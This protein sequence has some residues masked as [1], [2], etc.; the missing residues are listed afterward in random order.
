MISSPLLY[1]FILASISTS[2]SILKT[3]GYLNFLKTIPAIGIVFIIVSLLSI[4][5]FFEFNKEVFAIYTVTKTNLLPAI[6]FLSLLDFNIVSFVKGKYFNEIGCACKMGA[7]RYWFLIVLSLFISLFSQILAPFIVF[8]NP[9]IAT[10]II[11]IFLSLLSSFTQ[12]KNINGSTEVA[13]TMLY[14]LVAIFASNI[15]SYF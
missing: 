15:D 2:I 14:L 9:T 12:L 10:I 11:A 4:N 13:T 7:K 5:H 1:L 6:I 3:K 8:L